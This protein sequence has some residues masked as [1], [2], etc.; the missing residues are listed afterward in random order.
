MFEDSI[1]TFEAGGEADFC[2]VGVDI[3]VDEEEPVGVHIAA[4]NLAK[5]FDRV[6]EQESA[7]AFSLIST[8]KASDT[9][10][11]DASATKDT[12]KATTN[13]VLI[14]TLSGSPTIRSLV[15]DGKIDVNNIDGKWESWLTTC[16]SKPFD[17]YENALVIVGSDKRGAIF[18]AYNLAEQIGVSP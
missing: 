10:V 8:H 12:R 15:E 14:G 2:L 9:D 6:T 7:A 1:V 17:D 5:D 18:G 3:R 16:I 11:Q 13:C 4:E